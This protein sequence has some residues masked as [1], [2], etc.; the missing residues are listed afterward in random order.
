MARSR[1]TRVRLPGIYGPGRSALDRVAEGKAHRIDLAGQVFSRAHVE[2]I[3]SGVIAALEAPAG[4]YNLADDY[5]CSQNLVI[6]EACRLLGL[7]P[8]PLQSLDEAGLSPQARAFYSRTAGSRTAR[9]SGCLAGLRPTRAIARGCA[10]SAPAPRPA[11]PAPIRRRRASS[12]DSFRARSRTHR[13]HRD[14][15]VEIGGAAR[16]ELADQLEI[17]REGHHRAG[18]REKSERAEIA[19]VERQH[20]RPG[21]DECRKPVEQRA[22][23]HGPG[24]QHHDRAGASRP[25]SPGARSR[26]RAV[27]MPAAVSARPSHTRPCICADC[28]SCASSSVVPARPTAPPSRKRGVIRSPNTKCASTALVGI[29][30]A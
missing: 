29:I 22:V 27:T 9:R 30:S 17:E 12:S 3:A 18:Q 26:P 8:P 7:E 16:A 20:R 28:A 15:C 21:G 25:A 14:H 19:R 10:P 23:E 2:D 13:D 6:E 5:P 11:P 24:E 1:R 4:A